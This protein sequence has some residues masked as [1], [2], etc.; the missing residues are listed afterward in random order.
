M[1]SMRERLVLLPASR[2]DPVLQG[3]PEQVQLAWLNSWRASARPAQLPPAGK[4]KVWVILAGRGFGKTRA[5]AEWITSQAR[6]FPGCRIALIG[7]TTHDAQSV[8]LEGESGLMAVAGE[9]FRP[10]W[11]AG[12]RRLLWPNGSMA[13][14]FSAVE[15]DQLRGPQFHFGWCDEI[16]AWQRPDAVWNNLRMGLRLGAMPRIVVTTTP[17]PLPF[18]NALVTGPGVVVSRGSTYDN[19]ANLPESFLADLTAGYAG[20]SLGRQELQGEILEARE[21]ALWSRDGLDRCRVTDVPAL[22]RVVIG[23]DPPA[24]PGGCGIVAAG[25]GEDGLAYVLGDASLEDARPETWAAAVASAHERY[26]ASLVVAEVNNGGEMV[27]SVL[28]ATGQ[29][30]AVKDVRASRG[31][32]ARA[33]PVAALYAAGRVRHAGMFAALEDQMCGMVLGGGYAGP[34]TSPDRADA[35]VWALTELMLKASPG[36]P[37]LRSLA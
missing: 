18:L 28:K 13:T 9:K 17:R 37:G 31:K 20:T 30:L 8:M 11:Q 21:G 23:V 19:G 34:G 25:L 10:E 16:A 3:V 26:D 15:P 24:G 1:R 6:D 27:V 29:P 2:R 12:R 36:R 33:E 4:W 7:T 22:S 35:L 5:G 14:L 32:A